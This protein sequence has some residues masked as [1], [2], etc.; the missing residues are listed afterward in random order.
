M[1]GPTASRYNLS[2]IPV[3]RKMTWLLRLS[4]IVMKGKTETIDL[5]APVPIPTQ[6]AP[7]MAAHKMIRFLLAVRDLLTS[8]EPSFLIYAKSLS[9]PKSLIH[10]LGGL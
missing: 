5:F 7:A 6:R 1:P 10:S 8:P 2:P 4:I 3:P 9:D